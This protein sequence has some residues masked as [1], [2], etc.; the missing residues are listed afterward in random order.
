MTAASTSH[1][2]TQEVEKLEQVATL[3]EGY[4]NGTR[5]DP[6]QGSRES[7]L[8]VTEIGR[9]LAALLDALAEEY[10]HPGIPEQRTV[11]VALDQ[12]AA[13]AEDLSACVYRAAEAMRT[14]A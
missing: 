11:Q 14:G 2:V 5:I 7:L 9:Q 13:A 4:R 6:E 10:D 12:A 8:D 3:L 1:A